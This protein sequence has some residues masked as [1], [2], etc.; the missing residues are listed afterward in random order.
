MKQLLSMA[1]VADELGMSVITVRRWIS[2]GKLPAVRVGDH[3]IRVRRGDLES[4]M[5]PIQPGPR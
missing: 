2:T 5:T 4:V 1:E 3:Q